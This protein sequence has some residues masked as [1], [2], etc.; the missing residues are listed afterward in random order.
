MVNPTLVLHPVSVHH[1]P[2]SS[3][4]PF[5]ISLSSYHRVVAA[6]ALARRIDLLPHSSIS[7]IDRTLLDSIAT[8]P[9][10]ADTYAA[11]M[12]EAGEGYHLWN[13][14]PHDLGDVGHIRYGSFNKLYN[15]IDGPDVPL[16]ATNTSREE[17]L[18]RPEPLRVDY[19]TSSERS[20]GPRTSQRYR[21][22]GV[23][24]ASGS[25]TFR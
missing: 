1:P 18:R 17:R 15:A 3:V 23:G 21:S 9:S 8:M 22:L 5:S 6:L 24:G 20:I 11:C 13:P 7:D 25:P 10:Y 16:Y 12:H 4:P 14:A 2:S 19:G